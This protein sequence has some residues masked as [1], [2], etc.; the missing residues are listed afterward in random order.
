MAWRY[1]G[2]M[3]GAAVIAAILGAA[4]AYLA[5]SAA[6]LPQLLGWM[7]TVL[8]GVN[9]VGSMVIYRPILRHLQ[10]ADGDLPGLARRARRLPALSGAWVFGLTAIAMLGDA[11]VARGSWSPGAGASADSFAGTLAH[12]GVFSSFL[13][14]YAYLVALDHLITLR[15][16]LWKRGQEMPV[17]HR[18]LVARLMSALLI[19]ALGPAVVAIA[20]SWGHDGVGE[21]GPDLVRHYLHQTLQ[22]DVLGAVLLSVAVAILIARGLLRPTRIL[23]DA[24]DRVDQGDL[25]TRAPVVTDDEIGV[26]SARFNRMLGG[27]RER[28][29]L[30]RTFAYF[31]PESVASAL[32]A[33]E[34]AIAPQ[35]REATVLFAD[36]ERFTEI[37][38]RLPPREILAM[39]NDYFEE[40]GRA[41]N[42]KGGVI[43]QFQGDAVLAC[44][45]LPVADRDHARHAVEAALEIDRRVTAARFRGGIRLRARVG[46]STGMLVGGTVGGGERLG[47]T[48]HGDTVNLAARLEALNKETGTRVL[49][50]ART[51]E[52]VGA[53]LPLRSLGTVAVRGFGKPQALFEPVGPIMEPAAA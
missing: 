41:I 37:S 18:R 22:M 6:R 36:I 29:R 50:S 25:S 33:D 11:A 10:G 23:M 1:Y 4:S 48:V 31:V 38:S 16:A 20:D 12:C 42:D 21:A 39:L 43:T 40:V 14:L 27:L 8:V 53:A 51:A 32:V 45:N 13:G 7:A 35:E 52:L 34:G 17:T 9:L 3:M 28:E 15:K 47:Y 5:N 30:R 44:F 46:V 24:M 26:L 49:L 19:V 2:A